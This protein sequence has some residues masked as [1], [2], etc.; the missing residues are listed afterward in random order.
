[1]TRSQNSE[2]VPL[3]KLTTVIQY[4]YTAKSAQDITGPKYLRITDIQDDEVDWSTVPHVAMD[5]EDIERY[6]L[7]PGDIVFARSGATVG[8]SFLIQENPG[9][10]VFASY[11]IRVRCDP[12]RLDPRYATYFFRS[13]DYWRQI[14]EGAT[15]IGQP[16]FNGTKL[17]DL[18]IPLRPLNEQLAI[19][20]TLNSLLARTKSTR[21]ELR[22]IPRLAERHRQAVLAAAFSGAL[23]GEDSASWPQAKFGDLIAGIDAGKNV[24]CEERPPK[25]NER[26]IVKVS[27]VS[28]GEFD[29]LAS[30]TPPLTVKLDP[31]TR[32]RQGDFLISRANTIELVGACVI[33]RSLEIN[34]LYLSDKVLRIRF[35]QNIEDWVMHF[36]RSQDGRGQIETLATGNQLSMRN[37]SQVSLRSIS[38]PLPSEQVRKLV[39]ERLEAALAS[40]GKALNEVNRATAL[41]SRL[42]QIVLDKAFRGEL[43]TQEP[44][45]EFFSE[46]LRSGTA[47][48][49]VSG[50]IG[51]VA[52]DVSKPSRTASATNGGAMAKKRSEVTKNHLT[53][54]LG[55]MGGS[56]D[57]REL[58]QHSEM[59]IDEFYKQLRD[60]M[61]AGRIKEGSSKDRVRLA[62]AT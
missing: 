49:P 10:A 1:V 24:R 11:L 8:K 5:N 54:S 38:M 47:R 40:I 41:L 50:K 25:R 44:A 13:E 12:K 57:A 37:I 58:W 32:I 46:A 3:A 2:N 15:G 14:R 17:G 35:S 29:S 30:K 39:L 33:V 43:V 56:A 9:E 51:Q 62:N 20:S 23:T 6:R 48:G 27:S 52:I 45:E 21:E 42:D 34:N 16:N 61:K 28:W 55:A 59:D 4:G 7:L 22:R 26:G 60:E 53:E 31:K 18:T 19:V 36:L